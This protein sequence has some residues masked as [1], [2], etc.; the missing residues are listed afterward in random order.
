MKGH[1]VQCCKH[2]HTGKPCPMFSSSYWL[3]DFSLISASKMIKA[4]GSISCRSQL[5]SPMI[6]EYNDYK[7]TSTLQESTFLK[8]VLYSV[9]D[10]S[11]FFFFIVF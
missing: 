3:E 5:S 7:I 11:F 6:T 1:K 8:T 2:T 4:I 10:L 9:V